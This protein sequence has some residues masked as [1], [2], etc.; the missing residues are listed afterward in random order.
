M[1]I[2]YLMYKK[3][4]TWARCFHL[5]AAGNVW[6]KA[7]TNCNFPLWLFTVKYCVHQIS[8][9]WPGPHYLCILLDTLL[10][11][12]GIQVVDMDCC[13]WLAIHILGL[14]LVLG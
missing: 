5:N 10:P 12:M 9:L 1:M 2:P 6:L 13:I 14:A 8:W 4:H 11:L 3:P 7:Y